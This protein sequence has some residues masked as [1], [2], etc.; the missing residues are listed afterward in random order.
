MIRRKAI[1]YT[2]RDYAR[3]VVSYLDAKV[4]QAVAEP[5]DAVTVETRRQSCAGCVHRIERDGVAFCGACRCKTPLDEKIT[6]HP[7]L[8]CPEGRAGFTNE[9]RPWTGFGEGG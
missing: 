6:K 5:P 3:M 4:S 8:S 7:R 9:G 2:A 1:T